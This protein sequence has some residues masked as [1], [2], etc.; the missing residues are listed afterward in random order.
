V[1][2]DW[3]FDAVEPILVLISKFTKNK[4]RS[5]IGS[6]AASAAGA[7]YGINVLLGTH[8]KLKI[9]YSF[10]QAKTGLWQRPC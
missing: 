8:L 6:S 3:F 1:L 7:V 4:S 10:M 9:W 2:P 5:G